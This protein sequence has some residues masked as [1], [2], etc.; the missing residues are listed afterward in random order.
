METFAIIILEERGRQV[1]RNCRQPAW[2]G[3]LVTA[4]ASVLGVMMS[5]DPSERKRRTRHPKVIKGTMLSFHMKQMRTPGGGIS[6][7]V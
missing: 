2:G 3:L 5:W 7:E 6:F 4:P 1:N